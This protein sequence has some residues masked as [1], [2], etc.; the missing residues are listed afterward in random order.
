MRQPHTPPLTTPKAAEYLSVR[1]GTLEVWRTQGKGP[2]FVRLGRA[3][4]YRCKDLDEFL[5]RNLM[6]HTSEV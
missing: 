4:R 5:E 6:A 2:R 1:P 3:V